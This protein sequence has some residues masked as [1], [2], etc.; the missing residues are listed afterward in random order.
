MSATNWNHDEFS[1]AYKNKLPYLKQVEG[2]LKKILMG[3]IHG[4]DDPKLVRARVEKFRIKEPDSLARKAQ[5]TRMA[6]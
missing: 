3:V 5:A 6:I 1:A 4:L 2:L